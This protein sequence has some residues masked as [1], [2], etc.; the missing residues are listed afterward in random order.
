MLEMMLYAKRD[1]WRITAHPGPPPPTPI[2][3]KSVIPHVVVLR[4]AATTDG[5]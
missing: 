5:A 2:V 1:S 4:K 3:S